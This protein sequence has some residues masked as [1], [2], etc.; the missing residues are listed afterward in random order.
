MAAETTTK[1][2][3]C[4]IRA[5]CRRKRSLLYEIEQIKE[6]REIVFDTTHALYGDDAKAA[7]KP[8][9]T[10]N[11]TERKAIKLIDSIGKRYD[12]LLSEME[13]LDLKIQA[14]RDKINCC[15]EEGDMTVQEYEVIFY[16]YFEG[17]SNEEVAEVTFYSVDWVYKIKASAINVIKRI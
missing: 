7:A 3:L 13:L 4:E 9:T 5:K 12:D 1:Q 2:W 6:E 16:Y 14:A 15:F 17:M 10:S 8:S 11:P